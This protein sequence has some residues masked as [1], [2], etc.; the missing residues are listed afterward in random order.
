MLKKRTDY[1]MLGAGCSNECQAKQVMNY[2]SMRV[3]QQAMWVIIPFL[4]Y[5]LVSHCMYQLKLMKPVAKETQM[6]KIA[7]ARLSPQ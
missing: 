3:S 6:S 4:P 5:F 2:K 7:K 1:Y